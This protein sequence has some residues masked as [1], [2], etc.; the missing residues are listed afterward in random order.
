M[1]FF[2]KI[3]KSIGHGLSNIAK[4]VA[5]FAGSPFGKLLINVGLSVLTGGASSFLTGGLSM[6]GSLGSAGS[7][8]STFSGVASNFLGSASSLLSGSGLS[9]IA[10]FISKASDSS[11][12]LSMAKSLF[13]A[14]QQQPTDTSTN[15]AVSENLGQL[16]ASQ[17]AQQLSSLFA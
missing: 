14:R 13:T 12:L 17:Q 1:S 9:T 16:F 10:G 4:G 3:A 2:S 7:L 6:L 8:L 11:D 5:K 15:A